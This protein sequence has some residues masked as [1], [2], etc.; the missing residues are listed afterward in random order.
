V[1]EVSFCLLLFVCFVCVVLPPSFLLFYSPQCPLPPA[2]PPITM[3]ELNLTEEDIL[4]LQEFDQF[5]ALDMQQQQQ[6]QQPQSPQSPQPAAA[7]AAQPSTQ[8]DPSD[9]APGVKSAFVE[10][11]A[12][13]QSHVKQTAAGW[14]TAKG[15]LF[16]TRLFSLATQTTTHET[17]LVEISEFGLTIHHKLNGLVLRSFPI[18]NIQRSFP[19][20]FFLSFSCLFFTDF[21]FHFQDALCC[22]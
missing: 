7:A 6:Q 19:F 20:S 21:F 13:Q 16:E 14:A 5:L 1:A 17:F 11:L 15:A 8:T 2:G 12:T 3:D 22:E 9:P 10:Y 4:A 18:R